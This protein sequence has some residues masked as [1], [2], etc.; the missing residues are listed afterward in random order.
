MVILWD[1]TAPDALFYKIAQVGWGIGYCLLLCISVVLACLSL[2]QARRLELPREAHVRSVLQL[3]LA[4]GG[5]LSIALFVKSSSATV[6]SFGGSR[7]LLPLWVSTPAVLWPLWHRVVSIQRFA[8]I[9]YVFTLFRLSIIFLIFLALIT[10]MS[11]LFSQIP[12][13]QKDDQKVTLLMQKLDEMHITRFYTEYWSCARLVFASQEKL[14]CGDTWGNLTHGYD[15]YMPYLEDML[16]TENPAFV[17]VSTSSCIKDLEQAMMKNHISYR[18][19]A[20]EGY[21]IIQPTHRI[22]GVPLYQPAPPIP[23]LAPYQP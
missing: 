8:K 4:C 5:L 20:Y 23:G 13:A 17:Y 2:R 6:P 16:H 14:I 1:S 7:Y 15:R 12:N 18:Y 22:P 10:S 11:Y 19:T 21:I 3:L 9:Q